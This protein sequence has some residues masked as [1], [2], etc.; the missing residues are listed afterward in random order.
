MS[1]EVVDRLVLKIKHAAEMYYSTGTPIM[2]DAQFDSMVENLRTL[3]PENSILTTPGWGYKPKKNKSRHDYTTV[4]GL[5]KRTHLDGISIESRLASIKYDGL[6]IVCY[7]VEGSLHKILTRG[8]GQEG[9]LVTHKLE[10]KVPKNLPYPHTVAF[11]GECLFKE[12][13][14]R[15]K[16]SKDNKNSRNLASGTLLSHE[17]TGRE[18]DLDVV[19]YGVHGGSVQVM[20]PLDNYALQMEFIRSMGLTVAP[21][22][23][24]DTLSKD[25]RYSESNIMKVLE[26]L[27]SSEDYQSDGMVLVMK[28]GAG[29]FALKFKSET[30]ETY[31][32]NIQ[33]ETGTTGKLTP[34]LEFEPVDLMDTVVKRASAH[35]HR[36]LVTNKIGIG[37]EVIIEKKGDIIPQVVEVVTEAD[38]YMPSHCPSCGSE[39]ELQEVDLVCENTE[40]CPAQVRNS[41]FR[42]FYSAGV[43][44]GMGPTLIHEYLNILKVNTLS[45]LMSSNELHEIAAS[46]LTPHFRSLAEKLAENTQNLLKSM[47]YQQF[48]YIIGIKGLSGSGSAKMKSVD[49][50]SA[51]EEVLTKF[52]PTQPILKRLLSRDWEKYLPLVSFQDYVEEVKADSLGISICMTGALSMSRGKLQKKYSDLGVEIKGGVSSG[53]TYLICNEESSSSKSVAANKLNIPILTESQFNEILKSRGINA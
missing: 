53:L 28:N 39:L 41:M 1:Q 33:W 9:V 30:A 15:E 29:A 32:K 40:A 14:Y 37:S 12:S 47:K 22:W 23:K 8:D 46:I 44:E 34:V 19:F 17:P 51:T 4:V 35:N 13:V 11:K 16:Y 25:P 24:L 52:S 42:L 27:S 50:R 49:P 7:Y 3:S 21:Y 43:P 38:L 2:T 10:S 20:A 48:W 18:A 45:E 36:Y 26:E 31:V 6:S 5:P